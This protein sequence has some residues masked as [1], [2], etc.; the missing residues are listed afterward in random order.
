[1]TEWRMFGP[2]FDKA[3][4]FAIQTALRHSPKKFSPKIMD[5]WGLVY[6]TDEYTRSHN[7]W[8]AVWS[9]SYYVNVPGDCA[10]IVFP[11]ADF[12]FQPE[13]GKMILF[14]GHIAHYV[15]EHKSGADRVAVSGNIHEQT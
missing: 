2:P 10:P 13:N 3:I 9:F 6:R 12:S 15:P 11:G 5:C 8:P 4:D 1:M 7:H 14:L